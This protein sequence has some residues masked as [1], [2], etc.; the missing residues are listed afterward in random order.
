[1]IDHT[2][3]LSITRQCQILDV[4]RSTAYYT[5]AP[6]SPE[7]LALMR[8]IDELH[9]EFPFAGARMLRDLLRQESI[10]VGRKRISRLMAKMGIEALYR[11][12][13]TSKK[14]SGSHIYPYLLRNLTIDRPNQVWAT[15]ITYIPMRRGFVYLV[16][17]V[18]W[19]SRKVLS[20]RVSNT[21]TTDW[22]AALSCIEMTGTTHSCSEIPPW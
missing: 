19:Y 21:L 14:A 11:K 3:E 4:P 8:R 16:A 13:N 18:D 15:D 20:W 10:R 6:D 5:P 9:L 2:H 17:V 12:P 1:M 7:T 22:A